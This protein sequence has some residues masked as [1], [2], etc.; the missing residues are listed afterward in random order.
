ME[1]TLYIVL[2][3]MLMLMLPAVLGYVTARWFDR[4]SVHAPAW[5]VM[6]TLVAGGGYYV[7]GASTEAALLGAT[8]SG[9][10]A[11]AAAMLGGA[12]QWG[13]ML[14]NS[15][16]DKAF[17]RKGEATWGAARRASERA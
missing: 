4:W 10:A 8:F 13:M 16:G 12:M 14:N 1:P 7:F 9:L 15:S 2:I 11:L 17:T 3:L 6:A 5:L